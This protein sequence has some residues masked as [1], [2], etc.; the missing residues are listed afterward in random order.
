MI[1]EGVARDAIAA[2]FLRYLVQIE[3]VEKADF[4]DVG[5]ISRL[6]R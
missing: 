1:R 4:A 3:R 6:V 2:P 5:S